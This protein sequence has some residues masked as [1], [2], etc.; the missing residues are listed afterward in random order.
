MPRLKTARW[1]G[2]RAP[3]A[4][5]AAADEPSKPV[6]LG[7]HAQLWIDR[8]FLLTIVR[9]RAL[10]LRGNL[11]AGIA[12][13]QEVTARA[14]EINHQQPLMLTMG[15]A[16][17]PIALWSGDWELAAELIDRFKRHIARYSAPHYHEQ[18]AHGYDRALHLCAKGTVGPSPDGCYHTLVQDHLCTVHEVFVTPEAL[19]R[20]QAGQAGWCAPEIFRGHGNRLWR[21]GAESQGEALLRKAIRLAQRQGAR[22]WALRAATDLAVRLRGANREMEALQILKPAYTAFASGPQ[23]FDVRRA[24]SLWAELDA[25]ASDNG[26]SAGRRRQVD[27]IN[28]SA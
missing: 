27:R 22:F 11:A 3:D 1:A 15:L 5:R 25:Q 7:Y 12:L 19:A 28:V 2:V 9:A 26:P 4:A 6:R 21:G 18:W 24:G 8:D 23:V 20:A 10:F 13:A 16:A 14:S 17:C